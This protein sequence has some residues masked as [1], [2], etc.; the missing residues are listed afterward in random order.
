M[1]N[2]LEGVI[3]RGVGGFY[4]VKTDCGVYE[5]RGRGIFRKSGITPVV[6]DLV[7]I[8]LLDEEGKGVLEDIL[9][10]KNIF[11]RPPISNVGRIIIEVAV[12]DPAPNFITI[13]KLLIISEISGVDAAICFNK[14]DLI[15]GED[16][17][18]LVSRYSGACRVFTTS[19][20][21]NSG[22]DSLREFIAGHTVAFEGASGVGKSSMVNL[23]LNRHEAAEIG[24]VSKKNKRGRQTTRHVE[25]FDVPDGGLI[26]DTPGF[27][28][29]DIE[30]EI[31]SSELDKYYPEF[32]PYLGKCKFDNCKHISEP[33]CAVK[34]AVAE[35]NISKDRYDTYT[36]IY[37]EIKSKENVY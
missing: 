10:R 13:D 4:Y 28:S 3:V 22:I 25:L 20:K 34:S 29:F 1:N 8:S 23:L 12:K 9:P 6:G 37:E 27:S 30:K 26:F 2:K 14:T 33:G 32:R 16:L 7:E 21:D 11:R 18:K 35:G 24:S 31:E 19:V 15:S 5:T 17:D 36:Q